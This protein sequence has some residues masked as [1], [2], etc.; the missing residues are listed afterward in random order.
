[1][2]VEKKIHEIKQLLTLIILAK[3][4]VNSQT[5]PFFIITF[6]QREGILS[7]QLSISF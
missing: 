6:L 4:E 1:M 7:I 2:E 3:P 5:I